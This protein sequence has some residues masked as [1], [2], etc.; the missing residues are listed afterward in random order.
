MQVLKHKIPTQQ[1]YYHYLPAKMRFELLKQ[2]INYL[3]TTVPASAAADR[4]EATL[5][6]SFKET[7]RDRDYAIRAS[8]IPGHHYS[9]KEMMWYTKAFAQNKIQSD[10]LRPFLWHLEYIDKG[11][12][13][14]LREHDDSEGS[15]ELQEVKDRVFLNGVREGVLSILKREVEVDWSE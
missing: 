7:C 13:G 10:P 6:Q 12:L 9:N 4:Q 14:G 5:L 15:Q 1:R 2:I 3:S 11:L 8:T